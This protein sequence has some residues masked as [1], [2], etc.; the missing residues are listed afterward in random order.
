ML[1]A[2]DREAASGRISHV[3]KKTRA[4]RPGETGPVGGKAKIQQRTSQEEIR[5]YARISPKKAARAS[6]SVVHV[7]LAP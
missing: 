3:C 5:E 7:L 4:R 2:Q 1:G 6:S